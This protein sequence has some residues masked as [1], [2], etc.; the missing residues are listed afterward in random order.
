MNTTFSI[1]PILPIRVFG[2]LTLAA[3]LLATPAWAQEASPTG[4]WK[5]VDDVSGKPRALVRI[6]ESNGALLGRIEKVFPAPNEDPNPKCEKC[7]AANKNAPVVGLVILSG[8]TKEGD[9]YTGG[10]ILDPD[11][12]K[13]YRSTVRLT[14]NGK[15]LSVRGYIGVPMLGRSQTWLRQE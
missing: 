4:L 14:D 2:F 5:N 3:A 13:V 8:L 15:K 6:T 11:N 7:E 9:E 10:Q 12:G 1:R